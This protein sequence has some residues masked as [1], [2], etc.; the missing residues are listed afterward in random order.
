MVENHANAAVEDAAL[1]ERLLGIQRPRVGDDRTGPGR[2]AVCCA[3]APA[4]GLAG[5]GDARSTLVCRVRMSPSSEL[6][7]AIAAFLRGN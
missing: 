6:V 1:V 7:D 2:C 4:L 3:A 5:W